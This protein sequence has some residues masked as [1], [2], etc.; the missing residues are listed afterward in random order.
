MS[1]FIKL[2]STLAII[3]SVGIILSFIN[4]DMYEKSNEL[5]NAMKTLV[6][7]VGLAQIASQILFRNGY[8]VGC[9]GTI[10]TGLLL[11]IFYVTIDTDMMF[12]ILGTFLFFNVIIVIGTLINYEYSRNHINVN[13][14]TSIL[15]KIVFIVCGVL[16]IV[17]LILLLI[18]MLG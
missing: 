2:F 14:K 4:P 5:P 11:P 18:H 1:G 3:M 6:V 17:T 9:V 7:L 12:G 15:S 16:T 8:K 10:W 13:L